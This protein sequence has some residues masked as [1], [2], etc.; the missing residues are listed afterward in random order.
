[1]LFL[2]VFGS[3]PVLSYSDPLLVF[4]VLLSFNSLSILH[5]M[6]VSVLLTS[7]R[8][9]TIFSMIYWIC[10]IAFPYLMLQNPLGRG[11][12]LCNRASKIVTSASPGMGLHWAFMIIER[13]ER[14]REHAQRWS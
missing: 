3:S 4:V 8:M 2:F 14:F 10:S 7:S 6:F 1:M 5:A 12:Y 9:S 13:F 11:Y